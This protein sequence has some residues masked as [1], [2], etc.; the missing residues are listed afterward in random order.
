MK[1]SQ[2]ILADRVK[3]IK[4]IT[5]LSECSVQHITK[6]IGEGCYAGEVCEVFSEGKEEAE[7]YGWWSIGNGRIE[8]SMH[9]LSF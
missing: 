3:Q 7:V 6:L 2:R 8:I 1:K 9:E 4:K 5:D